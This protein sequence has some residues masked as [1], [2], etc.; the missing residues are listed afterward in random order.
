MTKTTL[1]N[2]VRNMILKRRYPFCFYIDFLVAAVNCLRELNLDDLY[3][4]NTVK[5]TPNSYNAIDLPNDYLDYV[6]VGIMAGQNVKN[7]VPTNKINAIVNRNSSFAPIKYNETRGN[8]DAQTFFGALYPF[9][10]NQ[11]SYNE[12]GEFTG[13]LFGSGA[14]VQDDVFSVFP[15]R[16]QIQLTENLS[17]EFV[18]L[19]YISDG[20]NADN[21]TQI[22]PYAYSTIQAYIMWQM[23]A[24]TR[25]YSAGEVQLAKQEYIDERKI[26]RARL[27]PMDMDAWKRKFQSA[28]YASP[29]SL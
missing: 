1:D 25:T 15:E 10:W 26:L 16:N 12:Y 27:D 29:K 11:V 28:S 24:N 9:Y 6:R 5:L 14:G 7:L 4:T 22:T 3:V 13:R 19:E 2:I 20:M 21:A 18:I 17:T 23:K 8:A